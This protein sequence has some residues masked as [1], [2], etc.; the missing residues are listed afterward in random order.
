MAA[1]RLGI[2]IAKEVEELAFR[3]FH[4]THESI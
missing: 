2:C 1:Y 3:E 4:G